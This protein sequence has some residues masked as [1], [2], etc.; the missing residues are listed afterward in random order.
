MSRGFPSRMASLSCAIDIV[1]WTEPSFGAENAE[2]K[3]SLHAHVHIVHGRWPMLSPKAVSG[4]TC[5]RW[6]MLSPE[7]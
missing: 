2:N 5:G 7:A 6:P 1:V 3:K 4:R